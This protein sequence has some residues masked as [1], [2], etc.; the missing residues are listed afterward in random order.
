MALIEGEYFAGPERR[1]SEVN[2]LENAASMV[3]MKGS[4]VVDILLKFNSFAPEKMDGWKITFLWGWLIL[5][6][7]TVKLP[8]STTLEP[9]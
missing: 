6:G 1:Q 3:A 2:H 7:G 4:K 5:N 9:P 8:R